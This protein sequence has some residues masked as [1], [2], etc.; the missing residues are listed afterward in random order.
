MTRM[1]FWA[2]NSANLLS[3]SRTG[4]WPRPRHSECF[5]GLPRSR[6]QGGL[7]PTCFVFVET[8]LTPHGRS[9]FGV[10]QVSDCGP[11]TSSRWSMCVL[12]QGPSSVADAEGE[13]W[14]EVVGWL[15]KK[16]ASK[17]NGS[18]STSQGLDESVSGLASDADTHTPLGLRQVAS[19]ADGLFRTGRGDISAPSALVVKE[20]KN[21]RRPRLGLGPDCG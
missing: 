10:M 16:S 13:F 21:T 19:S 15:Q 20:E 1:Q 17:N 9:V 4:H 11:L 2:S 8:K 3:I 12:P 7:L 14:E 6:G 18:R 5:L